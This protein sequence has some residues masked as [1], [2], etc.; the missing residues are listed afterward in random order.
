MPLTGEETRI[1]NEVGFDPAIAEMVRAYSRKPIRRLERMTNARI[2]P[3]S[4]LS[5]AVADG[6]EAEQLMKAIGAKLKESG[7]RAFWSK[8]PTREAEEVAILK[9][10]DPYAIGPSPRH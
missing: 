7:Y 10:T 2:E 3:A 1:V 8:R 6:E 9:T 4:G 5:V